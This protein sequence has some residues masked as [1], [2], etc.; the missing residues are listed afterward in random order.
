MGC[1][2]SAVDLL[3]QWKERNPQVKNVVLFVSDALRWDYTPKSILSQG[4]AFKAAAS[5]PMTAISFPSIIT[6]LYPPRL[7]V[8]TFHGS[9]LKPELPSLLN[10]RGYNTS[11][12]TQN[13]WVEY[14]PPTSAPMYKLLGSKN[15]VSL[16]E[17]TPPFIFLE[18]E[19]GGHCPYG[20]SPESTDYKEWDCA[21]FFRDYG[22]K[23]VDAMREKYRAG[24]DRSASEFEKRMKIIRE[25]GL[26][27]TTLVIFLADHGELLGERGGI[28]GHSTM[29]PELIY[30][31]I[32]LIHPD[33]PKGTT[34]ERDGLMRHVDLLPTIK[35][36][37]G[38]TD[39][40]TVDGTSLLRTD[41]LPQVGFSYYVEDPKGRWPLRFLLRETGVWDK[42]G[43]YLFREGIG[44]VKRVMRAFYTTLLRGDSIVAMYQRARLRSSPMK[45]VDYGE[46]VRW[47]S[48]ASEKFGTPSFNQELALSLA[49]E[50]QSKTSETLSQQA[51]GEEDQVVKDRL[52]A[53]GYLD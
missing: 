48:S 36:I 12:W 49:R 14:D 10:M 20:W 42:D 51:Y 50:F 11:I 45:L 35:D 38:Q 16:E 53:L 34:F 2:I 52:R 32:V 41:A 33:L 28:I 25:R 6:G 21:S 31:P 37:V 1:N 23:D 47:C 3:K 44:W 19:K 5:G 18:D 17:I 29:A 15:R 27:D 9:G 40:T 8:H 24:L 30:V 22:R 43:G 4:L 7:G 26:E 46:A 39:Q 13:T